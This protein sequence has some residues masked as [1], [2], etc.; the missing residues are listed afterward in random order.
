MQAQ[1]SARNI[2]DALAEKQ[3]EKQEQEEHRLLMF[4]TTAMEIQ[5]HHF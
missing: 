5:K 2:Q 4:G 3:A 1:I